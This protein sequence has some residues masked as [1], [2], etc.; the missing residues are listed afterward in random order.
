MVIRDRPGEGGG[1]KCS[2]SLSWFGRRRAGFH[3][4]MQDLCGSETMLFNRKRAST[5]P[6]LQKQTQPRRVPQ[7]LRGFLLNAVLRQTAKCLHLMANSASD[8]Q[9]RCSCK[10]NRRRSSTATRA[11]RSLLRRW[12]LAAAAL[13]ENSAGPIERH[14]LSLLAETVLIKSIGTTL[15]KRAAVLH[16]KC[17]R[18]HKVGNEQN[19]AAHQ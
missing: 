17:K 6:P 10:G 15:T 4:S 3:Q 16:G 5:I 11:T 7:D 2:L 8:W 1:A 9:W 19:K 13:R 14:S 18:A 12:P